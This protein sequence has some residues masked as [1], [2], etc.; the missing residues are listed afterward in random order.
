M[1]AASQP[2]STPTTASVAV[3]IVVVDGTPTAGALVSELGREVLDAELGT[4][5]LFDEPTEEVRPV[6]V[7][8]VAPGTPPAVY[9][10]AVAWASARNPRPGLIGYAP[11]GT[12]VDCEVALATG[13]DDFVIGRTST[14]ELAARIRAVHRRVFWTGLRRP[15]RLRFGPM[16]LDTDGHTLWLDG[17]TVVLTGT[18][19]AVLRALMR[20][21]GKALSRAELLDHAWGDGNLEISERAVDNVVLRLRRK[22]P[23]PD[24][25]RTVRGVGFRLA[26][27]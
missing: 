5:A 13:F 16:T 20:A 23:R 27:E 10:R 14:R 19:L 9:E 12:P 21:R 25:I 11:G 22:L 7:L 3:T 6:L 8:W 1:T 24:V 26:D 17:E 18:E 2:A 4:V 15:G